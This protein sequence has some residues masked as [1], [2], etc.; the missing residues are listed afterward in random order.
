MP[1]FLAVVVACSETISS[2]PCPLPCARGFHRVTFSCYHRARRS[3]TFTLEI[4]MASEARTAPPNPMLIFETLNAFQRTGALKAG[5]DL[6]IFTAI[7]EGADTVEALAQR[8][9]GSARG[10]RIL[11]DNL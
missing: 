10:I 4:V 7:G 11:C 3:N 2:C 1:D 8:T 9:G 6:D 5:I